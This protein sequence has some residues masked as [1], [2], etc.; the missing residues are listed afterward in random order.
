MKENQ[1]PMDARNYEAK[2]T[3]KDGRDVIIRGIRPD[4]KA[5]VEAAC[6]HL[7]SQSI[8]LRFFTTKSKLTEAELKWAT[9]VD[10]EKTVALVVELDEGPQSAIIG[11]GRYIEY[12]HEDRVRTA[13]IA[14]MVG[15]EFQ[16]KGIGKLLIK[17]LTFIARAKGVTRFEALVLTENKGMLRVLSSSGLPMK[18]EKL[19]SEVRVVLLLE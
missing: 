17:H 4:D 7:S 18:T 14:F 6:Q 13:E 19:G 2:A 8:Y 12:D 16:G 9:E 5:M 3:L 1:G 11:A 10:F 15:D